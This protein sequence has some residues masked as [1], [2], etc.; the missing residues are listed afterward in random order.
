MQAQEGFLNEIVRIVGTA[1]AAAQKAPQSREQPF[2]L[3]HARKMARD[4]AAVNDAA[5]PP[6][7]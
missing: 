6:H 3:F 5:G 1:P 2:D 4:D 7:L